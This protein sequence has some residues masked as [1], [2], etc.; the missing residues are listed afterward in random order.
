MGLKLSKILVRGTNLRA[1]NVQM[2]T[3]IPD[4]DGLAEGE[5]G[6]M[7]SLDQ[8]TEELPLAGGGRQLAKE[9]KEIGR[10]LGLGVTE[11]KGSIIGRR[12]RHQCRRLPRGLSK[13]TDI[14]GDLGQTYNNGE[15]NRVKK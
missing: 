6:R 14:N 12:G 2:T 9:L 5:G 10:K 1:I 8:G 11:A 15:T 7:G 3:K 13:W 4:M